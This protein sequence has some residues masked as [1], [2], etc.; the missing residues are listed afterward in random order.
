MEDDGIYV[1]RENVDVSEPAEYSSDIT[2][3]F[4][5]VPNV[6]KP[7]LKSAKKALQKIEQMLYSA[8]AFINL[9]KANVSDEMLQAVLTDEQ[10]QKISEGALKLM[11]KKDG[12]L[13]AT[14]INP[15]TNKIVATIPLKSVKMAPEMTQ[16]ISGFTNQMQMAQIAEEIQFVQ[17]AVEEVRQGQEYDRLAIAYSCQ[18]K[19]LQTAAINNPKLKSIALLQIVAEAEDSR[20]LLMLSQRSSVTFISEQPDSMIGKI[21]SGATSDKINA[22]MNEIRES[23]C[24]VNMVSLVEAMAYQEMGEEESARLSLQYYADFIR[25]TY[26]SVPG[27]V[28]RLDLIDPSTENY[29]SKTL[30]DIEKRIQALPCITE[31]LQVED[32][33]NG[34]E[35]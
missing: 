4:T 25:E 21:F 24:A 29:W 20:N 28:S 23:L 31:T 34:K 9:I 5:Q 22:R 30:P 14:L 7:L 35:E 1:C 17:L 8:P 16:A 2:G 12:S 26:L 27:L 15:E 11:T 19:M 6:A 13:M 18:Q 10:K 32:K 33:N 3:H